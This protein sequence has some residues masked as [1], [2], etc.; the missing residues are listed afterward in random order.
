MCV[1]CVQNLLLDCVSS[2]LSGPAGLQAAHSLT[3]RPGSMHG[4]RQPGQA[5]QDFP[6]GLGKGRPLT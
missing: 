4:L 2:L 6:V 1:M 5:R 3:W